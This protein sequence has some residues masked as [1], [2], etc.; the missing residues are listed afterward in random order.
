M[1]HPVADTQ[2]ARAFLDGWDSLD[3]EDVTFLER[4]EEVAGWYRAIWLGKESRLTRVVP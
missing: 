1:D 4:L 2:L 3:S